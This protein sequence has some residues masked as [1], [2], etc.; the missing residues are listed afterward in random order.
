[1]KRHFFAA[2]ALLAAAA[3]P[4]AVS[5]QTAGPYKVLKVT[6]T[7]G[8]GR[9]DYVYADNDGRRLYIPRGENLL[10]F[11]LDTLASVGTI[12]NTGG[13]GVVV[14]PKSH[15]GFS[16]SKQISMW[17]S[18]TLKPIKSIQVEGKPDGIYFERQTERVYILRHEAPNITV[19]DGK[20]G[21]VVGTI[22]LQGE[23]EQSASDGAGH[24]YVD[25]ENKDSVAVVDVKTLKVTGRYPLAGKGAT[26]A[27]L[28][29]DAKNHRL[30]VMCREPATCVVLD[31][32]DGKVVTT[33]PIGAGT[34][35]G[36][37]NPTTMEAFTSQRDGTLTVIKEKSPTDFA[38]EQTVQTRPGAKTCT[39]DTKNNRVVLIT[40]EHKPGEPTPKRGGPVGPAMLDIILVGR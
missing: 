18:R 34:D 6:R 39:L 33:L 20:T 14:D 30:F 4:A 36:A 37:F 23:P 15:H 24:L 21:N 28:G 12:P 3:M 35:G 10:V 7:M 8:T 27:G 29:L 22:D 16:S 38:V 13:H 32:T 25:L 17:D 9:V 31:S 19:I 5:A 26:P 11:S 40:L 1:M 2:F